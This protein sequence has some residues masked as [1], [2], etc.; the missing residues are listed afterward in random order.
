MIYP[1][2]SL[3]VGKFDEGERHGYGEFRTPNGQT[4]KG[5]WVEDKKYGRG[6]RPYH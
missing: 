4:Y 2:F 3:Y 6:T 5:N 1:D